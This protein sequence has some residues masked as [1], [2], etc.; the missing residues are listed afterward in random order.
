M[1]SSRQPG[2]RLQNYSKIIKKKSF[3]RFSQRIF[4]N[5]TKIWQSSLQLF[6]Y[7]GFCCQNPFNYP[8]D[9]KLYQSQKSAKTLC[10]CQLIP[11]TSRRE[12]SPFW[13]P[14]DQFSAICLQQVILAVKGTV[15]LQIGC[16]K[17]LKYLWEV[18][19]AK[20]EIPRKISLSLSLKKLSKR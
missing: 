6:A 12:L 9:R 3:V 10:D 1:Q 11:D 17:L 7:Y 20:Q 15:V 8:Q 16:Y 4:T 13:R 5:T 14:R 19:N 18:G 2:K